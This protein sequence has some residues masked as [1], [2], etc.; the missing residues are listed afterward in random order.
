M[1]ERDGELVEE[2]RCWR[3]PGVPKVVSWSGGSGQCSP[4]QGC[5][6]Q[7]ACGRSGGRTR[8]EPIYAFGGWGNM[9]STGDCKHLCTA[10]KQNAA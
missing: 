7:N 4:V 8:R 9:S 10:S 2:Q 3:G 5:I 6:N 1:E